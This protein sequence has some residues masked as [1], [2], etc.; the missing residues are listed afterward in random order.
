MQYFV[1]ESSILCYASQRQLSST[2][3]QHGEHLTPDFFASI[4]PSR[5]LHWSSTGSSFMFSCLF[6]NQ[7][8]IYRCNLSL[9]SSGFHSFEMQQRRFRWIFLTRRW[10][11][12]F[13]LS[14]FK[15]ILLVSV[16]RLSSERK[17][18]SWGRL[19]STIFSNTATKKPFKPSSGK[20]RINEWLCSFVNPS[21]IKPRLVHVSKRGLGSTISYPKFQD[22]A[23]ATTY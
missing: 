20:V 4:I 17:G 19:C 2:L 16:Q 8:T 14:R 18:Y 3:T 7:R 21:K 11:E 1:S 6:G 13:E 22:S 12:N 5:L 9:L 15:T 23:S 10:L